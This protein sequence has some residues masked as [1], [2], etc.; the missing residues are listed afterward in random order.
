MHMNARITQT[1]V[2]IAHMSDRIVHMDTRIVYEA[3]RLLQQHRTC[4][5]YLW[6]HYLCTVLTVCCR[7]NMSLTVCLAAVL[8]NN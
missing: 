7:T 8:D 2:N 6:N 5:L 4:F 3:A 1:D